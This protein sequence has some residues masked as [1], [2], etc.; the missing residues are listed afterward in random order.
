MSVVERTIL[1]ADTSLGGSG[2][3]AW[4][5]RLQACAAVFWPASRTPKFET[6]AAQW[7][8][9]QLESGADV[10]PAAVLLVV[11]PTASA[12]FVDRF[13][14]AMM[15]NSLAGV[16]LVK[17]HEAW[18]AQQQDGVLFE[19]PDAPEVKVAA[20]LYALSE[21]QSAVH[22]LATEVA[23]A[24]RC[25]EGVRLEMERLHEELNL[26]ASIQREF[27]SAPLPEIDGLDFSVLFRPV[28]FVSGDVYAV[29][30]LDDEHL[31]F[32]VADAVGHGVP[33]ALLT[34]VLANALAGINGPTI[35]AAA[36][37]PSD[38]PLARLG[39]AAALS[40]AEVLRRLNARLCEVQGDHARFATAVYGVINQRTRA[41]RIAGAG[42]P[43]PIVV[44]RHA[45]TT[46]QT[47]GPLLGVFPDA[48]FDEAAFTLRAG[49]SL[50]LYTD[51]L[52]AAFMESARDDA[53][54]AHRHMDGLLNAVR[55]RAGTSSLA[56]RLTGLIDNQLGSLHQADDVTVLAIE[57]PTAAGELRNAA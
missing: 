40:P 35:K 43:Y 31:G 30:P 28:N 4:H 18:R 49:E 16:A 39:A 10:R 1:I 44:G 38:P 46:I 50:L 19:P 36:D 53:N 12:T 55:D 32:L 13:M 24:H 47:E 45:S 57:A 9:K 37:A 21:R 29:R 48:V 34:M 14:Q 42:H 8:L 11:D 6:V 27:T 54:P 5:Q 22:M 26:A 20:L 23:L 33:A 56:S 3:K 52:E 51:G 15:S 7:L 25:Q 41:V 2:A 17:D